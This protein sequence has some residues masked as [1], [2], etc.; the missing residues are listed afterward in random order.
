MNYKGINK[1]MDEPYKGYIKES[2]RNKYK[3]KKIN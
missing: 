2:I 3:K 1:S